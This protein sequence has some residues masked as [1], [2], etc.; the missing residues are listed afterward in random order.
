MTN[1]STVGSDD[2]KNN[3]QYS[4]GK[5]MVG[6][7]VVASANSSMPVS[8]IAY[9]HVPYQFPVYKMIDAKYN[10]ICWIDEGDVGVVLEESP[11]MLKVIFSTSGVSGWVDRYYLKGLTGDLIEK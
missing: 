10:P 6:Q 11:V 3:S 9:Q 7:L 1:K 8:D 5:L 4:Y 2:L